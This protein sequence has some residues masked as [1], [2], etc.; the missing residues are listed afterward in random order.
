VETVVLN[1]VVTIREEVLEEAAMLGGKVIEVEVL[2]EIARP[3]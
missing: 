3:R 2:E 1:E